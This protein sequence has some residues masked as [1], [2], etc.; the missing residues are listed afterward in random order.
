MR[1]ARLIWSP[2]PYTQVNNHGDSV[3]NKIVMTAPSGENPFMDKMQLDAD[4][5]IGKITSPDVKS[6][7]NVAVNNAIT[8]AINNAIDYE[9]LPR[10]K[11]MCITYSGH[12]QILSLSSYP[13]HN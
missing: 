12:F 10:V 11:I 5:D 1:S 6:N 13:S 4:D 9:M 3:V 2:F 7:Q 8:N